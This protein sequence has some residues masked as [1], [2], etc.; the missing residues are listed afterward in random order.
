SSARET[1]E[2]ALA[3]SGVKILL[4]VSTA[5][6]APQLSFGLDERIQ[7]IALEPLSYSASEELLRAAGGQ[8]DFSLH[9]WVV[10]N[11]GGVPGIL[12]AA[13][14][15]GVRLRREGGDFLDQVAA[16]FEREASNRLSETDWRA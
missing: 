4:C 14:R 7:H 3:H 2:A 15:V 12:L 16:E 5:D 11:A 8:L 10:E 9:S 13:A 6:A 1:A